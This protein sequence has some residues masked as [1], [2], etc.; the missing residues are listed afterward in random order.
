MCAPRW[1]QRTS[2]L[3]RRP[4][5]RMC[6]DLLDRLERKPEFFSRII[7]GDESWILEYDFETKRQSWEWHTANSPRSKKARMSKSK[8]KSS[9][10]LLLLLLL[11]QSG[12][13]P[14]GICATRTNCQWNFLSGSPWKL[15]KRVARVRL[16]IARTWMLHHDNVPCHMAVSINEFLAG[17]NI[18]VVPQ[19]PIR[20]ISVPVTSPTPAQKPLERASF[21]YFG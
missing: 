1:F 2:R 9:L 5:G 11:L 3:S 7:T 10:L 20:Q 17:K 18:P 16:G 8:I 12:D 15:G 4:I 6:L 14:R 13:R 19:P 21:W